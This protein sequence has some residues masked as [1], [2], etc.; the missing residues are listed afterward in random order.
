M[1][2]ET[3]WVRYG[4]AALDGL[5]EAVRG[6]QAG[7]PLA[8]VTVVTPSPSVAVVTR[9]LLARR[10]GGLVGVSFQ[11]LG[12]LA[13]L[14][15][16]PQL[17]TERIDVGVDRELV[18]AAVRAAL[19]DDPGELGPIRHHRSTW[20]S[21]ADTVVELDAL[22]DDARGQAAA[23]GTLPAEMV[24][25]HGEV[26]GR[27]G[28]VG[29]TAVLRLAERM[30]R[31]AT[32]G[33]HDIGPVVVHLPGRLARAEVSLLQA[34]GE[35]VHVR[36]L[37]GASGGGADVGLA[38]AFEPLGVAVPDPGLAA[39]PVA[40]AI[41]S[42][43]DIDDEVRNVV[44]R[45][46][47]SAEAGTPLHR[48][49]LVH[50]RGAPYTRV[51]ADVLTSTGLP[52]AAPSARTLAQTAPG[53]VLA[54]VIAVVR[55]HF[56]RQDVVD[57]WA[58]GLVVDA[59][60]DPVPSA[61]FDD[62]SRRLGVTRGPV[63]WHEAIERADRRLRAQRADAVDEAGVADTGFVEWADRQLARNE[64]LRST[65][66]VLEELTDPLPGSWSEVAGWCGRV[67]D[68]L[69]G[70]LPRRSWPDE[71]VDA[72]SAIRT[73]VGRLAAL[74]RVEAT[75]SRDVVLDTIVTLLESPAPRSARTGTG[76]QV[77]PLDRPPVVPLDVVAI[78]GLVEGL[79]PSVPADDVL[80]GD[81]LRGDVG[82][83]GADDRRR[84]QVR[85]FDA[86][87][88]SAGH[89][90]LLS[91]ARHDQRSGRSLVP[92]RWVIDA[93]EGRTGVRPEAEALM[94]GDDVAGVERVDSYSAGLHAVAAGT[95]AALQLEERVFAD[96]VRAGG[97]DG[98]PAAT[99]PTIRS[100]AVLARSRQ[101]HAFTR[102]DG[103]L[104]GDGVDVTA[105]GVLSPTRLETYAT[106]PR[107]WFFSHA[108]KLR[109]VDRPEE[110]DRAQARDKGTLVH[111][112]LEQFFGEMIAAGAV[113]APGRAWPDEAIERLRGLIDEHCADLEARGLT[114]HPRWWEHD[115]AA[116]E[117][118]LHRALA[119]DVE[120]R[121]VIG[122]MPVAVEFSFGQG[123]S[124]PLEIDLGDGRIVE[125][126]GSADRIDVG[127]DVVKVWDY[128]YSGSR[129][130][131]DLVQAPEKGGD[132]LLAGTKLQLVAY[133]MAAAERHDRPEVE[134]SYWFLRAD[135]DREEVG[136]AI[137]PELRER[138]RRVLTVLADGI[139]EGRFPARPGGYQWHRGTHEHCAWCDFDAICPRDRDEEW[140]RVRLAP[141]LARL[142]RLAEEGSDS[143]LDAAPASGEPGPAV[144]PEADR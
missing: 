142:T 89:Q 16:A 114:G 122:A 23:G 59:D 108:L 49:A 75:P 77:T 135:T 138:F 98:H 35:R 14:L 94:A 106:C 115:R 24:R 103:N 87:L 50:P 144:A 109:A 133:G 96:L 95:V 63:R 139:G 119:R 44:R 18:V 140:E 51:V 67:L 83:S 121:S 104:R 132:P 58:T 54:G 107:K 100:G 40:S 5:A 73:A 110:I 38:R 15:A 72:D 128:K 69:C 30:V 26:R 31:D 68:A 112:V 20:E 28:P 71:E 61:A 123:Q 21:I 39:P 27:V 126:A 92:S 13:E 1:A 47:S 57:L 74:A 137:T 36:V 79:A 90:R 64:H 12:A 22:D 37:L 76:L 10:L 55:S 25:L 86:A 127:D 3:T 93:V 118:A 9:R 4:E 32:V 129:S 111:A 66:R 143:V 19:R 60:G 120:V 8:P 141:S 29:S 124:P 52:F 45:L 42:A 105:M 56:A 33:L 82:L 70:P 99:D 134:A 17:A 116:I 34:L 43:N 65:L 6:A 125:L 11:S 131:H 130:F 2:V 41:I 88:A 84:D 48:M 53:R 101:S 46:L 117:V 85:S 113:P 81:D 80:L 91:F 7:D 136:Y 102:F 78:V 62:A 97:L